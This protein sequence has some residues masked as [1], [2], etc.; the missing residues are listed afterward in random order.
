MS[1]ILIATDLSK[2]SKDVIAV[3]LELAK[4]LNSGII[5]VTIINE[6]VEYVPMDIGISFA[7]QWEARLYIAQRELDRIKHEHSDFD[8]EVITFVGDPKKD[9]IEQSDKSGASYIVIGT[10]GRTGF[11]HMVMGSTAEY[12][13]RHATVPVIVV[14]YNRSLH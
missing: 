8:I 7:D 9:V 2:S 6:L 14:P 12:V 4:K 11:S 13:I 10:H 5:L 1:K 3:G